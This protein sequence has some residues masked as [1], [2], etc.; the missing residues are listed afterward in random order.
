MG[1]DFEV[2]GHFDNDF[3]GGQIQ[4]TIRA[5]REP[6][7]QLL[8]LLFLGSRV[9]K[10]QVRVGGKIRIDGHAQQPVEVL[11]DGLHREITQESSLSGFGFVDIKFAA[12]FHKINPSV[13]GH[14]QFHRFVEV[15]GKDSFNEAVFFGRF[16]GIR[17]SVIQGLVFPDH[18]PQPTQEVPQKQ[19]FAV[20]RV[21]VPARRVKRPA[22]VVVVVPDVRVIVAVGAAFV[23]GFIERGQHLDVGVDVFETVPFVEAAPAF[24]QETRRLVGFVEHVDARLLLFGVTLKLS[25]Y[26]FVVPGPVVLRIGSGVDAH[27]SA[28]GLDVALKRH[29]LIGIEDVAGR[30]EKHHGAVVFEAVL[31]EIRRVFGCI[32]PEV[33]LLPQFLQ[34]R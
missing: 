5:H 22:P 29:L 34:G 19:G 10:I 4:K 12:T 27:K 8:C 25:T 2:D 21:G 33:S 3:F 17:F 6:R 16:Y 30:A 28:P 24:G 13:R 32:H 26:Q 15:V 7:N 1:A 18:V 23:A 9:E 11:F 14:G 20:T 31:R